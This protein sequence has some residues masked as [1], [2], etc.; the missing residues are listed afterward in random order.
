MAIFSQAEN[1]WLVIKY[2]IFLTFSAHDST[3]VKK[4]QNILYNVFGYYMQF[5]SL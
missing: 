1:K 3:R 4:I 5:L 2:Q